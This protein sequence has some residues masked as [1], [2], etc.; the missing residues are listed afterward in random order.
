MKIK[1]ESKRID[2]LKPI[3]IV[4]TAAIVATTLFTPVLHVLPDNYTVVHAAEVQNINTVHYN[5]KNNWKDLPLM[6]GNTTKADSDFVRINRGAPNNAAALVQDYKGTTQNW[7]Q[8]TAK[9]RVNEY[10]MMHEL[11][12]SMFSLGNIRYNFETKQ[13]LL[14]GVTSYNNVIEY[15]EL[16]NYNWNEW[17]E[18]KGVVIDNDS[19]FQLYFN[20]KKVLQIKLN[21]KS[22]YIYF[23]FGLRTIDGLGGDDFE[24]DYFDLEYLNYSDVVSNEK[25]VI[26]GEANTTIKQG[27]T[28]D[29]LSGMNAIDQ[30]DGNL[31]GNLKV[32]ENTVDS[33]KPGSYKVKYAVTDTDGNTTTFEREVTVTSNQKPVITGEDKTT[34]KEGTSFDPLSGM[35]AIDQEDGNLNGNLKVIEN[36]IDSKK[37]GSY[38]VK[39]AVTDTDG[40]TTTF[41]RE[42]IVMMEPHEF[43]STSEDSPIH[44]NSEKTKP[45]SQ[46]TRDENTMQ[47]IP[48]SKHEGNLDL[49][50]KVKPG[51]LP[52]AGG[53][54]SMPSWIGLGFLSLA[55]ALRFRLRKMKKKH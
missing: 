18:V 21:N 12:T 47:L 41:G 20:G 46:P 40:N 32:I 37:P 31:N 24:Y 19:R 10:T 9:F 34:I 22:A 23:Q 27:I 48:P 49:P 35:N 52:Q 45:I 14:D 1:K 3:K 11:Y 38:K 44:P 26:T 28:F 33:K 53:S 17:A 54:T 5:K 15:S 6:T 36:T 2:E 29:P 8:F 55:T 39:Y 4:T 30:E 51:K 50:S 13:W 42:V 25:P 7:R 43:P 16:I